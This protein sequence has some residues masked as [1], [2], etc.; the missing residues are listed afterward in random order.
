MDALHPNPLDFLLPVRRSDA[1]LMH[2]IYASMKVVHVL[3]IYHFVT[4][5]HWKPN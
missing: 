3:S 5:S 1:L 4:L 2:H